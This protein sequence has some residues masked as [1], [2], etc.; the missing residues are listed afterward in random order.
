[1]KRGTNCFGHA[2]RDKAPIETHH[3]MPQEFGGK[4]VRAN[5]ADGCANAHSDTHYF[6]NLLL[7]HG[8]HVPWDVER[9]F[10]P[11]VRAM[12]Q[13]GYNEIKKDPQL[14]DVAV[15]L[16]K[17]RLV[18]DTQAEDYALRRLREVLNRP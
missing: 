15:V 10:G 7:H 5:L 6:L 4:T 11:K 12:A 13:R 1:M 18:M 2:H 16:A 8:G 14:H 3:I 17:A 9:D